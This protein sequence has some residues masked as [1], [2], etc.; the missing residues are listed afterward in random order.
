MGRAATVHIRAGEGDGALPACLARGLGVEF[1]TTKL[2]VKSKQLVGQPLRRH[3]QPRPQVCATHLLP[4]Y[5]YRLTFW[6][7]WLS[8]IRPNRLSKF[9]G[10]VGSF[11]FCS[12]AH[13]VSRQIVP[14]VTPTSECLRR[15]TL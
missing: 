3:R 10:L 5:M 13:S 2:Q 11:V 15:E 14:C 4:M 8:F 9:Q 7:L 6:S 12:Y 1:M